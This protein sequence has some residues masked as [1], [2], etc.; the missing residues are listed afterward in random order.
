ML[1]YLLR[2]LENNDVTNEISAVTSPSD[3][4]K[5]ENNDV[6]NEISAVT[7][8]SDDMK[9]TSVWGGD[10]GTDCSH[11]QAGNKHRLRP[12]WINGLW[13]IGGKRKMRENV[14]LLFNEMGAMVTEDAEKAELLNAF[15]A[16]V[17]TDQ[18]SPQESQTSEVTEKVW[19]KEDFPLVEED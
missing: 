8:P 12:D 4:M 16:S 19:T 3:D 17:F 11:N 18:A 5:L 15:F 6:T 7:S 10:E 13:Y 14:G 9:D 1:L 2:Q